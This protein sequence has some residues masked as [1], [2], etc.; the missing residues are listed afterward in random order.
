MSIP[1]VKPCVAMSALLTRIIPTDVTTLNIHDAR[2]T[3]IF[4]SPLVVEAI[5][6]T[7]FPYLHVKYAIRS[8]TNSNKKPKLI[9][10]NHLKIPKK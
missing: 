1:K 6:K 10:K 8:I 2:S 9:P 7:G 5:L 4:L 3:A